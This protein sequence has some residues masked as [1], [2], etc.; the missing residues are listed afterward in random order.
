M[1][2]IR[3]LEAKALQVCNCQNDNSQ[4]A[5]A[6]CTLQV[7]NRFLCEMTLGKPRLSLSVLSAF[8]RRC[9]CVCVHACVPPYCLSGWR[10]A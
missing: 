8:T 1:K 10:I 3:C 7:K 6:C 4:T 5:A 9:V 2:Y